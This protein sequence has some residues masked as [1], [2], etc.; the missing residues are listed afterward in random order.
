[1]PRFFGDIEYEDLEDPNRRKICWKIITN[2]VNKL[3]I[4]INNSQAKRRRRNN[5]IY[6]LESLTSDLRKKNWISESAE[7]NL[8]SSMTE[9]AKQLFSLLLRKRKRKF[10]PQLRQFALTLNF[11]SKKAYN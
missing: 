9:S 4:K 5:K 8:N 1:M 11:Y 7:M 10:S 6:S 3:K 2:T